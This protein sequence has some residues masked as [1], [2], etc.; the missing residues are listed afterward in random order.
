MEINYIFILYTFIISL[1][2]NLVFF[3]IA[4]LL[5]SDAFTDITY[6]LTFVLT[7]SIILG[8]KQNFS[9]FQIVLYVLVLLWAI[10]LGT[11]LL[12]RI[13]KIKVDH[14]FDKMRNSF[15]KFL[16]FWILQAISVFII[17]LPTTFVLFIDG[18]YFDSTNYYTFIFVGI[19]LF[20]LLYETIGD[21]QKFIFFQNKKGEFI[22]TGLWK[23]SRHPNYFGE[24]VF[25]MFLTIAFLFNLILKNYS[26]NKMI[27]L[28]LLWLLSPLYILLLLNF[29]SGLPLLEISAYKKLKDNA[30]YQ[31]YVQKTS[32]IIPYCGKKGHILRVKKM[33]NDKKINSN[34]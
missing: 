5:K 24:I 26:D 2:L 12:I 3:A 7:T 29:V 31:T 19:S 20:G 15:W 25:W 14:R 4:F 18:S 13:I 1:G 9:L 6:A 33:I 8:W 34:A 23:N 21:A 17:V 30:A 11:Y 10:R 22:Q 32:A 16:G 28:Q 27:L